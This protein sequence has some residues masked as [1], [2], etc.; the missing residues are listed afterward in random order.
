MHQAPP[1]SSCASAEPTRRALDFF[2]SQ[3]LAKG[4]NTQGLDEFLSGLAAA[5]RAAGA[6]L[7]TIE[8]TGPVLRLRVPT[9]SSPHKFPV[10]WEVDKCWSERVH[11]MRGA[12]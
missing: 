2:H 10:P 4:K 5:F 3:L 6:G 8:A 1:E 9:H 11:P 12:V 7:A